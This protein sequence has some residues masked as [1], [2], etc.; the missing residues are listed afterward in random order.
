[1]SLDPRR[2]EPEVTDEHPYLAMLRGDLGVVLRI[3]AT[4]GSLLLVFLCA[5][6]ILLGGELAPPR[7]RCAAYVCQT[8][9]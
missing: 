8:V 6:G 7:R 4:G 2:N 3:Y 5:V 9:A 1:M